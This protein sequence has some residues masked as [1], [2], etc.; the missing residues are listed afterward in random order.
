MRG[1]LKSGCIMPVVQRGSGG[2]VPSG[3]KE[4]LIDRWVRE[5]GGVSCLLNEAPNSRWVREEGR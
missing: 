2:R 3:L 5:G 4:P 1:W